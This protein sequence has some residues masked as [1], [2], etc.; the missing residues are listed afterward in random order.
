MLRRFDD[1][2]IVSCVCVYLFA[3]GLWDF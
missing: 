1:N 2:I 3:K